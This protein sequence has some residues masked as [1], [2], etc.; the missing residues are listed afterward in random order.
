MSALADQILGALEQR[1]LDDDVRLDQLDEFLAAEFGVSVAGLHA[2]LFVC[3]A[4]ERY[5]LEHRDIGG[6]AGVVGGER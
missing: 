4:A 1:A 3:L 6:A 5:A 2:Y